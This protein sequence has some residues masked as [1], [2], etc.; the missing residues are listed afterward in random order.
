MSLKDY[1]NSMYVWTIVLLLFLAAAASITLKIFSWNLI[2]AIFVCSVFDILIKKFFL[3]K[4]LSFPFSA[5][6]TGTIIGSI[7]TFNAPL[8]AVLTACV[9]AIASKNLVRLKF[10][11]IFNPATLG[12]LVALAF[13]NLGDEWWAAIG[14]NFL[15]LIIPISVILILANYKAM[16]L[17]V[18]I[19]FLIVVAA[20]YYITDFVKITSPI[21]ILSFVNVLPFYFAFIM[22]SEP[23]TSPY[24]TNEQIVF[25]IS[26]A[27]LYF[28]LDF[29]GIKFPFFIALLIGNLAYALYRN[30]FVQSAFTQQQ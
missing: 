5:F 6:I 16:K 7:I 30:Y 28:S 3:K 11:H 4:A 29:F 13:F 26:L 23:K 1:L 10:G 21:G 15:G 20:L 22:L 14:F 9:F 18:S 24:K 17:R 19:P 2:I 8:F 12:L 25:G 27:I